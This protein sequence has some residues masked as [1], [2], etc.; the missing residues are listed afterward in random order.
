MKTIYLHIGRG[1]TGTTA[2]QHFLSTNR[3]ALLAGGMDYLLTGDAGQGHQAFA[4]SFIADP[5]GY[6]EMPD[7]LAEL[8]RRTGQEICDSA[9]FAV[10]LSSENF[11]LADIRALAKWLD[12]LPIET[13]T[14]VIFFARSQDEV[15]ESEYNQ[16]V[17][18]KGETRPFAVYAEA[19]EGA[20]YAAECDAWAAVFGDDAIIARVYDAAR[21]TIEADFLN[22]LPLS[23]DTINALSMARK[24]AP[25]TVANRSLGARALQVL[26]MLNAITFEDRKALQ[27]N[28]LAALG[29][30]DIPA[31]LMD[32]PTAAQYRATFAA[33]NAQFLRRYLGR[34]GSDLGGR[35]FDDATRD[36]LHAEVRALTFLV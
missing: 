14:K 23:A 26:L 21:D 6:M 24:N 8:R 18:L 2:L 17:K 34:E 10:L 25:M 9:A 35:R 28:L 13:C 1:K 5:P 16:M 3:E 22:C 27:S 29:P 31:V 20:D 36:R 12:D 19:L 15:A 11:P 32:A 7:D 33:S 30:E 4:K